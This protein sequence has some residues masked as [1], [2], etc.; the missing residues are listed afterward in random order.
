MVVALFRRAFCAKCSNTVE[1]R[2]IFC[3]LVE[4]AGLWY[5]DVC[6]GRNWSGRPV[7]IVEKSFLFL[8][9]GI[10]QSDAW[11]GASYLDRSHCSLDPLICLY[12]QYDRMDRVD[13]YYL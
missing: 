11:L 5:I 13:F 1:S 2:R 4:Y 6:N 8:L 10:D 3:R 7:C 9:F 12:Q